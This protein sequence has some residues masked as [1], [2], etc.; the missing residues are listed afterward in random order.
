MPRIRSFEEFWPYYLGEHRSAASRA[1]HYVGT[2]SSLGVLLAGIFV[3]PWCLLAIPFVGYVPAWVGHF[4]IERN[5]PATF[6]YPGWSL[7]GDY[8]MFWLAITGRLGAELEKLPPAS[9]KENA[10]F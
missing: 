2:V 6:G 3:S 4:G 7:R 5:Q 9:D 10:S 8:K 1:L